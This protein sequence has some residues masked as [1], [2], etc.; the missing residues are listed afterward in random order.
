M[1][2]NITVTPFL[3]CL[4]QQLN[5]RFQ[6]RTKD[7]IKVMS[8][9]LSSLVILTTKWSISSATVATNIRMKMD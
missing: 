3:D 4:V 1:Q 2:N 5:D 6:G 7:A 8:L 9:I